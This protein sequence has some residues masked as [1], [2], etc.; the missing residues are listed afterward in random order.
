MNVVNLFSVVLFKEHPVV[1]AVRQRPH[2]FGIV[3][4][5]SIAVKTSIAHTP[6]DINTY[7]R[8][9]FDK[10]CEL[11]VTKQNDFIAYQCSRINDPVGA[12]ESVGV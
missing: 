6:F 2:E 3:I 1:K 11:S 4:K 8:K 5:D 7:C 12:T 9:L 10:V